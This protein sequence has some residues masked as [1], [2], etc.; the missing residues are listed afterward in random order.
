MR[1]RTESLPRC[2]LLLACLALFLASTGAR[3][4]Q[5]AQYTQYVFNQFSV[6]P[7]VAGSKDCLDVRLC[8]RKQWRGFPGSPSTGLARLHVGIH[9]KKPPFALRRPHD[10]LQQPLLRSYRADEWPAWFRAAGLPPPK[11]RGMVFDTSLALA[12]AAAQGAGVALLP[13]AL[14][15]RDLASGRLVQP[16]DTSIDTGRYWLTWLGSRRPSPAMRAFAA[17]LQRAADPVR[18][19]P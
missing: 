12:E 7:A 18:A 14:F 5:I 8:F 10:L 11:L 3:A 4:Q 2:P 17:W 13:V 15:A 9:T 6:N 1:A 19:S 16:F